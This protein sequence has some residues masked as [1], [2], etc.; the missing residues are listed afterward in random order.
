MVQ[1]IPELIAS[2]A[3]FQINCHWKKMAELTLTFLH[4]ERYRKKRTSDVTLAWG[5]FLLIPPEPSPYFSIQLK[6]GDK[7]NDFGCLNLYHRE[8]Y[9]W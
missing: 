6:R 5:L 1:T 2:Q 9:L 3:C 8:S 7:Y 4:P